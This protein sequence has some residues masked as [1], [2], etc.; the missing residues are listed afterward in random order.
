MSDT[1]DESASS[2][3]W[4]V[5]EDWLM[6]VLKEHHKTNSKIKITVIIFLLFKKKKISFLKKN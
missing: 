6:S 3:S 2:D 4:P 1:E 5:N